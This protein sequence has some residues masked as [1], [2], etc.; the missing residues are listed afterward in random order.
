LVSSLPIKFDPLLCKDNL[1]QR[2]QE[3]IF[4]SRET[5]VTLISKQFKQNKGLVANVIRPR[6][7][8]LVLRLVAHFGTHCALVP[9]NCRAEMP[10]FCS[11][12]FDNAN[13]VVH[14][15]CMVIVEY[16]CSFLVEQKRP[17]EEWHPR[18]LQVWVNDAKTQKKSFGL[19]PTIT[20]SKPGNNQFEDQPMCVSELLVSILDN[21]DDSLCSLKKSIEEHCQQIL[22]L[23]EL[24]KE[25]K[26]KQKQD[27]KEQGK[28]PLVASL[29]EQEAACMESSHEITQENN[30][31][32]SKS[33]S[34][35]GSASPPK[36]P[37]SAC[38]TP[39]TELLSAGHNRQLNFTGGDNTVGDND[40]IAQLAPTMHKSA[41]HT[42][43]TE[44]SAGPIRQLNFTVGDDTVGDNDAVAQLAPTMHTFL[45]DQLSLNDGAVP[46]ALVNVVESCVHFMAKERYKHLDP[47]PL[48]ESSLN[49]PTIQ[50][51]RRKLNVEHMGN[52]YAAL[53]ELVTLHAQELETH[54]PA[55]QLDWSKSAGGTPVNVVVKP[56]QQYDSAT[57]QCIGNTMLGTAGKVSSWTNDPSRRTQKSNGTLK[58]P[59]LVA[60]SMIT[61]GSVEPRPPAL[62][63]RITPGSVEETAGSPWRLQRVDD[64][65]LPLLGTAGQ[66]SSSTNDPST[67]TK[68]INGALKPP[69]PAL[70]SRIT[71]GSVEET[72]GSPWRLQRG[73]DATLPL[74]K[75]DPNENRQASPTHRSIVV[76]AVNVKPSNNNNKT[77]GKGTPIRST[78][79]SKKKDNK[80]RLSSKKKKKALSPQGSGMKP[81][82]MSLFPKE[83]ETQC[84]PSPSR[85]KENTT[86]KSQNDK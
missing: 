3:I 8:T 82:K 83:E 77:P 50:V 38:R 11:L 16:V 49:D 69:P 60:S 5:I 13:G 33:P 56:R 74:K 15:Y 18:S 81:K 29:V 79:A 31:L 32:I 20:L 34:Q 39:V 45:M 9:D 63:S 6:A 70:S 65:T 64:A 61:P 21:P 14:A 84:L 41:C 2:W 10:G 58:P 55:S 73:D 28:R 24:K 67:Q 12:V 42:P 76:K 25:E 37:N 19:M 68:E 54:Y 36:S 4:Q 72:A 66:V 1:K 71:P 43:V 27:Q 23:Q 78:S 86:H 51:K 17:T 48:L 47:S 52:V 53:A 22:Q 40:A 26:Q 57:L 62:S 75:T 44:L 30:L 80:D 46:N 35:F 85:N 59:P 7:I